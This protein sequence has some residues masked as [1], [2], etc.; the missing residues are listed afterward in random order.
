[1]RLLIAVGCLCAAISC[2]A[3]APTRDARPQNILLVTVDT[4]RADRVGVGIAPTMDRL[5]AQGIKFANARTVA[6]L[7]LPAHV[8]MVVQIP[9]VVA[10]VRRDPVSL[11]DIAPPFPLYNREYNQA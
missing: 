1:M 4:L 7:T 2:R 11:V 9:G 6:P 5:A 8:S 10:A 3:P